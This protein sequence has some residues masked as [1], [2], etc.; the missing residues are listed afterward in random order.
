M[1]LWP[2]SYTA[3]FKLCLC[4]L[5]LNM[6]GLLH[7]I[8]T[9]HNHHFQLDIDALFPLR[10]NASFLPV[11]DSRSVPSHPSTDPTIS[12][13]PP[14]ID[15]T[16]SQSTPLTTSHPPPPFDTATTIPSRKSTHSNHSTIAL[17]SEM[18]SARTPGGGYVVVAKVYEQQ[19]MASGNL[20]QLQCW[21][22]MLNMSLVTPFMRQ[23][24][25]QTPLE[26]AWRKSHL[27][28]WDTFNR[29]H[30]QEH[31]QSHGYL[32]LV[33]WEEW[34]ERG[35][36][37]LIV[38]QLE[39]RAPPL[40]REMMK[41]GI[42]FPH[43]HSG[44]AFKKGCDFRFISG[45]GL[46]FL[47]A[48]G[49]N[50]TRKVCFNFRNGDGFTF[51]EFSDHLFGTFHPGDVSVI[52]NLWR[53][54]NEPQRVLI[55]EKIC[56]EDHPFRE[57]V[58]LSNHLISEAHSY[59]ETFLGSGDYI[60]VMARFEMTGLTRRQQ[61]GNDTHA[62][63]PCCI[64]KTLSQL[65]QLRAETGIESTFLSTDIGKYGSD[66]F[67]KNKFYNHSH[68]LTQFVR[69][70]YKGRMVLEDIEH[71]LE[72]VTQTRDSGYIASLQQQIVTQASCILFVG[73]GSFQR[74]TLH[75]YKDLHPRREDQCVRVVESCTNPRRPMT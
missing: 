73:G 70:M 55:S 17:S 50:I 43:P 61:V 56:Y 63:I 41:Q 10:N 37:Q 5:L 31:A 48:K 12:H 42:K 26:E 44:E 71:T 68:E 14:S 59:K 1:P 69:Q 67:R 58:K 30:W 62:E 18:L 66:S 49:F 23:S 4:V 29:D 20:L 6:L 46:Q 52:F 36:R 27:S 65:Q 75:M 7:Y 54:L 40:V 21:A 45:K 51:K 8:V 22:S 35:P 38:V 74:H 33:D 60:A 47:R 9:H 57:Q 72:H 34:V 32:P 2:A 25:M 11:A 64:E 39:Y 3:A 16:F 24:Y 13:P 15:P 28:F 53:G 19:T